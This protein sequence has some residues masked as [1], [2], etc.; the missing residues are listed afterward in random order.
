ML[1]REFT[2]SDASSSTLPLVRSRFLALTGAVVFGIA[3]RLVA[4]NVA[5]A[6]HNPTPPGCGGFNECDCCNGTT[7]SCCSWPGGSHYHCSSTLQCWNACVNG[8]LYRC[9]DWHQDEV[10][11]ICSAQIGCC[12]V[13][14]G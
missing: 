5:G 4:P 8:V 2:T 12:P 11:C 10:D 14:C 1:N 9:C 3:G 6:T 7:C 13:G